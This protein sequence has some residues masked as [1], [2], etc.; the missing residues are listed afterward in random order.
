MRGTDSINHPVLVLGAR[1]YAAVY[2]DVHEADAAFEIVGFVENLDRAFCETSI[3]DLRVY[4][5]DDIASLATT[6]A[7]ICCLATPRRSVFID[8]VAALGFPFATL[9]HA[10]AVISDRSKLSQGVSIDVGVIVAAFTQLGSHVR[11]GRGATIG[12]HTDIGAYCT[13]HPAANIAGN[14]VLEPKVTIGMGAN[15]I[16]GCRIGAGSFVAAG[17]VV[18]KDVP[19]RS[20]V[21]GVPARVLRENYEAP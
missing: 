8:Q 15:V 17:A 21:G 9:V 12:H 3:L 13:I 10:T 2:A 5:I 19:A 14:C 18:T 4:W 7:A 20:L 1:S 16:D 6:H 11:V